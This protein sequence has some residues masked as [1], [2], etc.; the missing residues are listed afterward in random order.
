MAPLAGIT[1]KAFR[2]IVMEEGASFV[3]TEM[4]SAKAL[5]YESNRT[6]KMISL[7]GEDYPVGMQI[8]GTE[9]DTMAEG[10]LILQENGAALIDINM[11]CPAPKIVKSG[12][13]AALMRTPELAAEIVRS[14]K[15]KV[16]IPVTVKFRRAW[17]GDSVNGVEFALLMAEAGADA[18]TVHGRTR[19]EF[20]SGK[21]D[22]GIIGAI[23]DSVSVP[24]IGNGDVFSF[25]RAAEMI[26]DTGCDAVMAGRGALGNPWLFSGRDVPFE[27]KWETVRRHFRYLLEDKGEY[28]GVREFRKHFAWYCKGVPNASRLR[29]MIFST[30]EAAEMERI[31]DDILETGKTGNK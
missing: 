6:L 16:S 28:T 29:N 2:R 24:V 23:S 17:D 30:A 18:L 10:A 21:A 13:G 11:G 4:I 5:V 22:W 9:P 7:D 1:D 14:I 27:E 20:Y 19:R 12:E 26:E 3:Y 8:F 31:I 15:K 25:R